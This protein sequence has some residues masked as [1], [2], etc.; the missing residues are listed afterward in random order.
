MFLMKMKV[1]PTGGYHFPDEV[2]EYIRAIA[3]EDIKGEIREQAN[4]V[5]ITD[6]VKLLVYKNYENVEKLLKINASYVD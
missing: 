1:D 6:F 2:L 5:S 3:P 4:R